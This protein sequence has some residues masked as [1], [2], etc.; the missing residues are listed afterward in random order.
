[1]NL[2]NPIAAPFILIGVVCFFY[3][4]Y[5]SI[6]KVLKKEEYLSRCSLNI[7]FFLSIVA[8]VIVILGAILVV[9]IGIDATEWWFDAGFYGGI[10]GGILNL[11]LYV[12]IKLQ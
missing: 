3:S 5:F 6:I 12:L 10:I 8:L 9:I 7:G 11:L 4:V 1:M 2:F